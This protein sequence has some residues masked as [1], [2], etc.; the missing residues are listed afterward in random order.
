MYKLF[1][2]VFNNKIG[3]YQNDELVEYYD[4]FE[5]IEGNIYIAKVKNIIDGTDMAFCNI[6]INKDGMLQSKDIKGFKEG[7]KISELIDK[8]TFKLVQVIKNPVEDKGP[9]LTENIKLV[10]RNVILM[11]DEGI[12][13]S[14]KLSDEYKYNLKK[15][16]LNLKYKYGMIVRSSAMNISYNELIDEII[17]LSIKLDEIIMKYGEAKNIACLYQVEGI[18]E[19]LIND[20]S[21]SDFKIETNSL[22]QIELLKNKYYDLNVKFVN[23]ELKNKI[24]KKI[25]LK[26]GGYLIF[27]NTVAGTMI[28][29]NSGRNIN[30]VDGV[31][32]NTN[33]EAVGE[34]AKQIRL[35]DLSGIIIIDFINLRNDEE[36]EII[37]DHFKNCVKNDRGRVTGIDFTKLR[38]I[39]NDKKTNF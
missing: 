23:K 1:L 22:E 3:V 6:G 15:I 18:T 29:V 38:F 9:K 25:F 4:D 2:D 26:L 19:K 33:L 8:K 36:R 37:I 10:G 17:E 32:F 24:K 20:L 16:L 27:E 14:D 39:G 11:F 21:G 13:F 5:N 35:R 31:F 34:I 30:S 7:K 28:D 12:Y